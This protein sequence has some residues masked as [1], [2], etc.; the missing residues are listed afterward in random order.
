MENYLLSSPTQLAQPFD[1]STITFDLYDQTS[2]QFPQNHVLSLSSKQTQQ[3]SQQQ[4]QQPQQQLELQQPHQIVGSQHRG[5]QE[6]SHK[7][8]H[9]REQQQP[10][11][12]SSA[13]N[14]HSKTEYIDDGSMFDDEVVPVSTN[15][16]ENKFY[17]TDDSGLG[18]NIV[19]ADSVSFGHSRDVSLDEAACVRGQNF[20]HNHNNSV[21]SL[22][23]DPPS[24]NSAIPESISSNTIYSL[25]SIPSFESPLHQQQLQQHKGGY[26]QVTSQQTYYQ[27]QPMYPQSQYQQQPQQQHH[28]VQQLPNQSHFASTPRRPGRN[29][30][31]SVSSYTTPLRNCS[32]S[33]SPVNLAA[34]AFNKVTKTPAN[35]IKGHS[36]SRSRVSLDATAAVL[37]SKTNSA[38]SYNSALNPFYTPSQGMNSLDDEENYG[39]NNL[40]ATPLLTPGSQKLKSSQ[41]TFFSPFKSEDYDDQCLEDQENDALKQLKKAKSYSSLIKKNRKDHEMLHQMSK[42]PQVKSSSSST[43]LLPNAMV[44]L[45]NSN[46]EQHS[47]QETQPQQPQ[48]LQQQQE[49]LHDQDDNEDVQA[50]SIDLLSAEFDNNGGTYPQFD[51]KIT[52]NL[53][54][55]VSSFN[56]HR[57]VPSSGGFPSA[58]IDLSA[59][60]AEEPPTQSDNK[61]ELN[62]DT[63]S[64]ATPTLLPPMATFP[65]ESSK[66]KKAEAV[67]PKQPTRRSTRAKAKTQTKQDDTSKGSN[68]SFE[69]IIEE[70]GTVTI[71]IPEDLNITRPKVRNN[72]SEKN[73]KVDP[74]KKH[75]CPICNSRFQRPEHVKRHL[76]SH[77]SEKPF[78]CEE[79]NCGKCFNRK[80]NLKAHLKKIHG[81]TNV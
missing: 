9:F 72:R 69:S 64:S 11:H 54:Q 32:Q 61:H 44:P 5:H 21:M 55:S 50:H 37:A 36:R 33:F 27:Q 66:T 19:D 28:L 7:D 25:G 78:Q 6:Y 58:S 26:Q 2:Q 39:A 52:Q 48:Q 22:N 76:K 62:T 38:S 68:S 49:Y 71:A 20:S 35:K 47:Q 40:T 8:T 3:Q 10:E 14:F 30:S 60:L 74:R 34:T 43:L 1:D 42:R 23:Q 41:S 15:L 73:D 31:M 56:Q 67:T 24:Q 81:L 53:N 57:K 16:P 4:S 12:L 13:L 70:D 77:S 80:D 59:N 51:K 45:P 65:V 17:I 75:K 18:I 79:P 29:K 46:R 63:S